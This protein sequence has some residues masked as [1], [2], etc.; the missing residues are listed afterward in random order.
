MKVTVIPV[1]V[2]VLGTVSTELKK[3]KKETELT[4]NQRKNRDHPG[5][6]TV[7]INLG[8]SWRL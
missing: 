2:D 4:G 3:K 8:E 6:S 7:K 5:H 1:V